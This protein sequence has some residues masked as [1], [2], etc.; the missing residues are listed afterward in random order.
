MQLQG[1]EGLRERGTLELNSQ[2]CDETQRE[3]YER[4]GVRI[5]SEQRKRQR[6]SYGSRNR[7]TTVV[8]VV[9][10]TLTDPLR[11]QPWS[12]DR[13]NQTKSNRNITHSKNKAGKADSRKRAGKKLAKVIVA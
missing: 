13:R 12:Q 3:I 4:D 6:L 10:L 5:Q 1:L 8:V 11:I 2:P 9:N 7:S